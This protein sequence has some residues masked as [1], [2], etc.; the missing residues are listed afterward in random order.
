MLPVPLSP[1]HQKVLKKTQQ[2]IH[3]PCFHAFRSLSNPFCWCKIIS[4]QF[5]L[6]YHEFQ[7]NWTASHVGCYGYTARKIP[8]SGKFSHISRIVW[9]PQKKRNRPD[10]SKKNVLVIIIASDHC[11]YKKGRLH[12]CYSNSSLHFVVVDVEFDCEWLGRCKVC[13]C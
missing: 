7:M 12:Q 6:R 8:Y 4:V 10:F 3:P 2:D 11:L 9:Q 13:K 5:D 1:G